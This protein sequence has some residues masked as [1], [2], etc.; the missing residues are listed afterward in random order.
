MLFIVIMVTI[1]SSNESANQTLDGAGFAFIISSGIIAIWMFIVI[2]K[3]SFLD[4]DYRGVA[5]F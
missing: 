3:I 2:M 5:R 1:Y 4:I